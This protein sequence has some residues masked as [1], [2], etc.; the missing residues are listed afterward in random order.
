MGYLIH[1]NIFRLI[2]FII[3]VNLINTEFY[4]N[5]MCLSNYYVELGVTST[6]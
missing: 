1:V 4:L 2:L 3:A 5:L 6:L